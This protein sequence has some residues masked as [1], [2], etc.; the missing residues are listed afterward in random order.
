M[1]IFINTLINTFFLILKSYFYYSFKDNFKKITLVLLKGS[2]DN[3]SL[4]CKC[5]SNWSKLEQKD[6][7]GQM[8]PMAAHW[9]FLKGLKT[10]KRAVSC[11]INLLKITQPLIGFCS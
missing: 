2:G 6:L 10:V 4:A 9:C 1:E 8:T 5:W 11:I 3:E 7:G